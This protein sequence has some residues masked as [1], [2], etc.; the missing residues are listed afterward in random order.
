MYVWLVTLALLSVSTQL[1]L[2]DQ[3]W[4]RARVVYNVTATTC[5]SMCSSIESPFLQPGAKGPNMQHQHCSCIVYFTLHV[6]HRGAG[7]DANVFLEMH[8][9]KGAVGQTRLDN[10]ANNFERGQ[11]GASSCVHA[12]QCMQSCCWHA[13]HARQNCS[14][15]SS[16]LWA[17]HMQLV[18]SPAKEQARC[19]PSAPN[20]HWPCSHCLPPACAHMPQTDRPTPF[21]SAARTSAR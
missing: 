16:A 14:W 20:P 6:N 10:A 8:G 13:A 3:G 15:H 17:L 2:L 7:T 9:T 19:W 11:V 21:V 12:P 4:R 18:S 1:L 5:S